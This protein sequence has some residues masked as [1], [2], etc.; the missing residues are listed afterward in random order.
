MRIHKSGNQT[1]WPSFRIFVCCVLLPMHLMLCAHWV[2]VVEANT[3]WRVREEKTGKGG[4]S[5]SGKT[6]W[7]CKF[8]LGRVFVQPGTSVRNFTNKPK[9]ISREISKVRPGSCA[10]VKF[11]LRE[12]STSLVCRTLGWCQSTLRKNRQVNRS[13]GRSGIRFLI[14]WKRRVNG[15]N[16]TAKFA[17]RVSIGCNWR[18]L[19]DVRLDQ[20]SLWLQHLQISLF[21][22]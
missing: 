22:E 17:R 19:Q 20:R 13:A 14:L 3:S 1:K 10:N 7:R 8:F 2:F 12:T 5:S 21:H 15:V 16:L 18:N 9:L 6:E 11:V 4:A